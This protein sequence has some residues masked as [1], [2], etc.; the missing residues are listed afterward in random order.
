MAALPVGDSWKEGNEDDLNIIHK[1]F[2]PNCLKSNATTTM[3][4]TKV[5]LFRE[6]IVMAL[7]CP[8]C[9]FKNS[10]ISFGGEI[11]EKGEKLSLKVTKPEDL[12]RQFVK[13]DSATIFIPQLDLEIPANTQRGSISTLEGFLTVAAK[14][15]EELQPERL[16]LGD[17]D[18]FYRCKMVIES[19]RFY[20]GM[21]KGKDSDDEEENK[22]K[23]E[24]GIPKERFPFDIILDDPAGN[25]FIENPMAPKPDPNMK[26]VKYFRTATQDMSLGLQ[27]SQ[28][29]VEAGKIDDTNPEHKHKA[30]ASKGS[31]AIDKD[32]NLHSMG[33]QE[34]LKF[35]TQCPNCRKNAE[36]DMCMCDI[37]HFKEIIIMSLL[38]EHCGY[39]SSEIK[40]GGAIPKYGN[41]ITL[42]IRGPDDMGR[43]ILKSDTAGIAIPELELELEEG[44]LDGMYT[45]IE[46]LL[47]KLHDRL[48]Q[49][50]PFGSGDASEKHH[51]G[52]DGTAFAIPTHIKYREF[53]T[54]LKDASDGH[55]LPLTLVISDPLANSF[56]GPIPK[57]ALDLAL[58]AEKDGNN[59]C[60]NDYVDERMEIEEYERTHEQNEILG[61][62]DMKTENYDPENKGNYGT[63]QMEEEP[64]RIRRP[65]IRGPDHPH[66]VGKA[67]VEGDN[68]VMG[69]KSNNFAVPS[70]MQRGRRYDQVWDKL[71]RDYESNDKFYVKTDKY[72]GPKENMVFKKG[73][74]GLG[75]Y[76]DV[77]LADLWTKDKAAKAEAVILANEE[78]AAA[79][80]VEGVQS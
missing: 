66:E 10:E 79:A 51:L 48:V 63:D 22:E 64:D 19:L 75:Y 45:S 47:K 4:P 35:P 54:K 14:N 5:P 7:Y 15:L 57:D 17:L 60:Y 24:I 53:L 21:V 27:P 78:A 61:L 1:C 77:S 34:V 30:N 69:P 3:L 9:Y 44:G 71:I 29:A 26:S 56:I 32:V 12:D 68:T 33:R 55:I 76:T 40:G 72:N 28:A 36:T 6:L 52:N 37:P 16:R 80:A 70:L 59:D 8:D 39:R 46:G 67:P 73:A 62:N 43:E 23:E 2:C 74:L 11:Q 58:K 20:A 49:A 41:K 25:S 13:S 42:T 65:D 18:N 50:N 38:C 31:H